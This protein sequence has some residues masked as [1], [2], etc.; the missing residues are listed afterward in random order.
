MSNA[1]RRPRLYQP[2]RPPSSRLSAALRSP[3]SQYSSSS[4]G[5][6]PVS[7]QAPATSKKHLEQL[8]W[9][10]PR[11]WLQGV[12]P[13][14]QLGFLQLPFGVKSHAACCGGFNPILRW[15]LLD[16]YYG[17]THHKTGRHY[18]RSSAT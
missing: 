5:G 2:S 18:G 8:E 16:L 6:V 14:V 9:G 4:I 1:M 11:A 10:K 12:I 13:G 17:Q 15:P 7:M 3:P